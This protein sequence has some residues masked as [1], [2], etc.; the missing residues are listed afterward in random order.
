MQMVV[1]PNLCR[2]RGLEFDLARSHTFVE[3]DHEI[4]SSVILLSADSKRV[5]DSYKRKYGHNVLVNC[6]VRL[7]QEKLWLGQLTVST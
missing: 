5:V 3:I 1:S 7:A 6:L 2:P 4:L